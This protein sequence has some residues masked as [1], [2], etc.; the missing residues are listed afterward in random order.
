MRRFLD[1]RVSPRALVWAYFISLVVA[2]GATSL[3]L[4]SLL[5]RYMPHGYLEKAGLLC[6]ADTGC[7]QAPPFWTSP[8]LPF[9]AAGI[10]LGLLVYATAAV[11]GQL[12]GSRR[13]CSGLGGSEFDERALVPARL[14]GRLVLIDDPTPVSYTVGF[15]QPRVVISSGLLDTLDPDEVEAVLAHEEG[16]VVGRDNLLTLVAQTLAQTFVVVPGVRFAHRRLRW[17]QELAA[18]SFA[19]HRTGDRLVVA[20]SLQKFARALVPS[21]TAPATITAFADEGN[22][23]ERI[24]GLVADDIRRASRRWVLV[25]MLALVLGASTFVGSALAFT[26]VAFNGPTE[27]DCALSHPAVTVTAPADPSMVALSEAHHTR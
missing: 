19:C 2:V 23:V 7:V 20:S 12:S 10:M 8:T 9:L 27:A 13:L 25:A 18:D 22:V 15:L 21:R 24:R 26:G 16:H 14:L 4:A 5:F 3:L 11:W 17:A 6:H 1:S